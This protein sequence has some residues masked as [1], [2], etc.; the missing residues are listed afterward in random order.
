M[1]FLGC[2]N[3][4]IDLESN[5]ALLLAYAVFNTHMCCTSCGT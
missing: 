5:R 1:I 4:I 3:K 2:I